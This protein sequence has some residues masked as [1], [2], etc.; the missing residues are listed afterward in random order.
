VQFNKNWLEVT[1]K[2]YWMIERDLLPEHVW[3]HI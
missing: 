3:E 1:R 2:N